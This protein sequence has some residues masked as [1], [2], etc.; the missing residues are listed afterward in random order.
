MA[1]QQKPKKEKG[2]RN[3]GRRNGKAL[4]RTHPRR[5]SKGGVAGFVQ[6]TVEQMAQDRNITYDQMADELRLR[7]KGKRLSRK[8]DRAHR[9]NNR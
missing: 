9:R 5:R 8:M 4:K 6:S 3:A 7:Q 2:I 1:A